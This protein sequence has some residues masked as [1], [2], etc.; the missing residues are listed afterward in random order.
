MGN[1][2]GVHR[3]A[4]FKVV[5]AIEH[6]LGGGEQAV[7]QG[8]V[9]AQLQGVDAQVRIERQH[10]RGRRIDLGLADALSR[11]GDLALQVGQV[12]R[13]VVNQRQVTDAAGGKVEG[14]R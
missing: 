2:S 8:G 7:Q 10:G 6:H 1:A 4:R 3:L 11:V 13:I 14:H 5:A 12:D 9:G